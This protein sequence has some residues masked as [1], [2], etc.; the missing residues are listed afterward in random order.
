M[1]IAKFNKVKI[2]HILKEQNPTSKLHVQAC[3]FAN[4]KIR[5]NK[6]IVHETLI[7]PSVTHEVNFVEEMSEGGGITHR[8]DDTYTL[9]IGKKSKKFKDR[10]AQTL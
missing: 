8:L 5:N 2:Q 10:Y 4:Y 9:K 1:I 6:T 7:A 3:Q